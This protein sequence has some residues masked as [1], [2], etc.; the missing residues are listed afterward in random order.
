MSDVPA[1]AIPRADGAVQATSGDF[2][3]WWTWTRDHFETH[4]GP[5]WHRE[6]NGEVVCAFRVADK[7]INGS[8][9]VHGGAFMTFADYCLF[10]IGSRAL[11]S[12][13]GV[14]LAVVTAVTSFA[15]RA[16]KPHA[17]TAAIAA[18]TIAFGLGQCIGPVLSGALSDGPGGVRIGLWLSV[19]IL[20]AA[21]MVAAFQPEPRLDR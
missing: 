14:T 16:A 19:G 18:L 10:A 11:E 20:A 12:G 9:A 6:E 3:G 7:H 17:W 21:A 8:G 13:R 15:R 4:N 2:A 5:Y 1:N